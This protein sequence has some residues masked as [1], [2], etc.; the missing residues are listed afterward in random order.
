MAL[1]D[2]IFSTSGLLYL[3]TIPLKQSPLRRKGPKK[4]K[5]KNLDPFCFGG[6]QQGFRRFG[7]AHRPDAASGPDGGPAL[8]AQNAKEIDGSDRYQYS[9]VCRYTYDVVLMV[10]GI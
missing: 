4:T 10:S 6:T 9:I 7:G 1:S 2:I 5:K 3:E 8:G